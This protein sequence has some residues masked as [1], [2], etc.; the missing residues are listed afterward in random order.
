LIADID[1]DFIVSDGQ[2]LSVIDLLHYASRGVAW[3]TLESGQL[4]LKDETIRDLRSLHPLVAAI[5][6]IAQHAIS[7]A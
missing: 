6:R 5:T 3:P 7:C 1:K 4:D 2:P